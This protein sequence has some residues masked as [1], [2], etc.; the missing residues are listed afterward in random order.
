MAADTPASALV[1]VLAFERRGQVFCCP[2]ADVLEIL[3]EPALDDPGYPTPLVA[4]VLL[5]GGRFIAAVDPVC[6]F[7]HPPER[8]GDVILIQ[9]PAWRRG[10]AGRQR[11]GLPDADGAC[12]GAL[13]Y[14]QGASAG[15]RR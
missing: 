8:Q 4:G 3:E 2:T 7:D 5:Y 6:I 14:H 10:A 1:P 13:D 9:G 11:A 15:R 12:P